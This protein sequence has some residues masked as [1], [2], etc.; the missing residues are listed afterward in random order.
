M[1]IPNPNPNPGIDDFQSTVSTVDVQGQSAGLIPLAVGKGHGISFMLLYKPE[2][3]S[4]R[5]RPSY[6]VKMVQFGQ[7]EKHTQI[8]GYL[9]KKRFFLGRS[10]HE[11]L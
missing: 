8:L 3:S 6:L 5:L 1:A 7:K 9:R 10:R 2:A 11:P 4:R